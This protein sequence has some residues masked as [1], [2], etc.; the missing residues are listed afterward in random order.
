MGINKFRTTKPSPK[1]HCTALVWS[2]F[3]GDIQFSLVT[4]H[5]SWVS[6]ENVTHQD[7]SKRYPLQVCVEK[8]AAARCRTNKFSQKSLVR[9][10][11]YGDTKV[12]NIPSIQPPQLV[13]FS[14]YQFLYFNEQ[15]IIDTVGIS[16]NL[17]DFINGMWTNI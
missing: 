8:K 16:I 6:P 9:L 1:Y 17:E 14:L 11:I 3:A 5:P 12:T 15:D 13:F 7:C 4:W 2:S 10:I